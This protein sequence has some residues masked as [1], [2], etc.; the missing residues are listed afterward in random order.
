MTTRADIELLRPRRGLLA[1]ASKASFGRLGRS[2]RYMVYNELASALLAGADPATTARHLARAAQSGP[3]ILRQSHLASV[4][5]LIARRLEDGS[6]LARMDAGGR[7]PALA[8]LIPQSELGSISLAESRGTATLATV[9][10]TIAKDG[11]ER[12]RALS[13]GIKPLGKT[14]FYSLMMLGSTV[15]TAGKVVPT[16][17]KPS[18]YARIEG[19]AAARGYISSLQFVQDHWL[20]VLLAPLLLLGLLWLVIQV[21]NGRSRVLVD[22]WLP[23]FSIQRALGEITFLRGWAMLAGLGVNNV[24]ALRAVAQTAGRYTRIRLEAYA[25]Q[26]DGAGV[27]E[28]LEHTNIYLLSPTSAMPIGLAADRG[29]DAFVETLHSIADDK[30]KQALADIERGATRVALFAEALMMLMFILQ[31]IGSVAVVMAAN[32][33]IR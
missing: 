5:D 13:E 11:R 4:A 10:R 9:L 14:I 15:Y 31:V 25:D 33:S 7:P 22:F 26:V 6:F 24:D 17:T 8:G 2:T 21:W 32:N 1:A 19:S 29:G 28:G 23:P 18:L 20:L 30:A 16:Y 27:R 12:A 3:W